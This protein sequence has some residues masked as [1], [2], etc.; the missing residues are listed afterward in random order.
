MS[1]VFY[2]IYNVIVDTKKFIRIYYNLIGPSQNGQMVH[3]IFKS[4]S[5]CHHKIKMLTLMTWARQNDPFSK[6]RDPFNV[7][8]IR[9]NYVSW[10]LK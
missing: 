8:Y 2:T 4:K 5:T 3:Q 6:V 9:F 10:G 1:Y 7:I